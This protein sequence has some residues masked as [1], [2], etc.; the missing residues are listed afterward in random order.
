MN[1][2]LLGDDT[3]G[4]LQQHG[5]AGLAVLVARH[6]ER[7]FLVWRG[8]QDC[9]HLIS[10]EA[11]LVTQHDQ[12]A[13]RHG[14]HLVEPAQAKQNRPQHPALRVLVDDLDFVAPGHCLLQITGRMSKDDD[15]RRNLGFVK[16]V[17]DV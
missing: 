8:G 3:A 9:L 6:D 2:E 1:R 4:R 15:S 11:G 16:R 7:A 10:A 17:Q 5:V 12:R 14:P 13:F